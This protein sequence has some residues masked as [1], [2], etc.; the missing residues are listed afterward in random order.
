MPT[1]NALRRKMLLAAAA[2]TLG[3]ATA[4]AAPDPALTFAQSLFERPSGRDMTAL[5]RMELVEKGREPR[6]RELVS[7]R[8]DRGQGETAYLIRFLEPRDISGTGLLSLNHGDG[9]GEQSLFLPELDR[10][11]K[12]SG[13]RKG[14]RFV[15][16]DLYFE[17][18][19]ERKPSRDRHALLGVETINGIACERLES[20]PLDPDDSIYSRRVAWVDPKTLITYRVDYFERHPTTP[21]KRLE[22]LAVKRIQGFWTVTDSRV[23]DLRNGHMTRMVAAH[24]E[25]DRRLPKRL[26]T[27]QVLADEAIESEYRP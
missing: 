8:Q 14:G 1:P 10:V 11:R 7:Y 20:T 19:Q 2:S 6:V 13:D 25:Y 9:D 12:V 24:V 3:P 5:I 26:F 22:T 16:S 17:D 4:S 21:T 15:G 18:L 23:T 27:P